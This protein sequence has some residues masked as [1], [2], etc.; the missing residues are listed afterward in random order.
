M[1]VV[2]YFTEWVEAEPL[3]TITNQKMINFD[4]KCIVYRFGIPK[5]IIVDNGKQ[6]DGKKFKNFCEG[7]TIDPRFFSVAHAQSNG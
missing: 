4:W 5:V 2:D 1:V 6:F 7:L 3:A